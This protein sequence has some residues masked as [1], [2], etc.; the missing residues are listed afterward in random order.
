VLL[1]T[2]RSAGHGGGSGRYAR[3]E[4]LAF[5]DAWVLDVLGLAQ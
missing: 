3:W 1:K 2:E 5:E 4:E